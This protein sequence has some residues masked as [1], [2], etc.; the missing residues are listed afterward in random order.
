MLVECLPADE[1][2]YFFSGPEAYFWTTLKAAMA[3]AGHPLDTAAELAQ[4][5]IGITPAVRCAKAGNAVS[6]EAVERCS[7]LLEQELLHY[8]NLKVILLMGDAAIKAIN[9]IGRRTTRHALI[10]GQATYRIR[11]QEFNWRGV[12]LLPSYL[13]TGKS[14]LIEKSKQTMVAED[15]RTALELAGR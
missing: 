15:I 11:G 3:A 5:G 14:F 2:D 9:Y 6:R 1:Q 4:M 12:R 13:P 7:H 8:S 10:P